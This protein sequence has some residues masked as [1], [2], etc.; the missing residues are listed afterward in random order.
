MYK[1]GLKLWSVNENYIDTPDVYKYIW[2]YS[3]TGVQ[4][5]IYYLRSLSHT[6]NREEN[7]PTQFMEMTLKDSELIDKIYSAI[8]ANTNRKNA[9]FI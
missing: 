4:K 6:V 8:C 1:F 5:E 2:G 7:F 9:P 3:Y